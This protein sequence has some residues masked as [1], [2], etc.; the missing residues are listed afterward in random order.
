M[1]IAFVVS[2]II[3]IIVALV[4]FVALTKLRKVA[5]TPVVDLLSTAGFVLG[6]CGSL[7]VSVVTLAVAFFCGA[8]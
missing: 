3:N 8:K 1:A 6:M 5:G 7:V 4:F 2:I